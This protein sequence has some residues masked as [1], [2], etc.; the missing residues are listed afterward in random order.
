MASNVTVREIFGDSQARH[1]APK[2]V[3]A[4]DIHADDGIKYPKLIYPEHKKDKI[5]EI[6]IKYGQGTGYAKWQKERYPV[7]A[8]RRTK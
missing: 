7:I 8:T 2:S 5:D 6:V 1:K 3:S 4:A